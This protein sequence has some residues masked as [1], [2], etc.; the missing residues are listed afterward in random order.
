MKAI[1]ENAMREAKRVLEEQ[2]CADV[3]LVQDRPTPPDKAQFWL[4]AAIPA[5]DKGSATSRARPPRFRIR[6]SFVRGD[7][8]KFTRRRGGAAWLAE[9]RARASPPLSRAS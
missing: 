7:K 2:L 4:A 3:N 1:L 6:P 9:L 5:G 8:S